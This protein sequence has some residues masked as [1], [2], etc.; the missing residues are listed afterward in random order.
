MTRYTTAGYGDETTFPPCTGHPGDPRTPD[1]SCEETECPEC[2]SE[3][4]VER[5]Q[6]GRLECAECGYPVE[7]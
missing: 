1:H 6:F 5:D 3:F 4:C 2:G 7:Q